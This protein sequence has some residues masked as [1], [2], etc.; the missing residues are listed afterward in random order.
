MNKFGFITTPVSISNVHEILVKEYSA[1]SWGE[2]D[3]D[4]EVLSIDIISV[5]GRV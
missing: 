2:I 4:E 1:L 5:I 3:Y